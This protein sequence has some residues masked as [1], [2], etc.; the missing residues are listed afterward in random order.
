MPGVGQTDP[1]ASVLFS[2]H[3]LDPVLRTVDRGHSGAK[4]RL[5][6]TDNAFLTPVR[7]AKPI[8]TPSNRVF[9]KRSL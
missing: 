9:P 1:A 3:H 4:Q 7:V 5:N 8:A 6:T 2:F